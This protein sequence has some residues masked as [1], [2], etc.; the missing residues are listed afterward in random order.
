MKSKKRIFGIVL[1]AIF[2]S[3]GA[4]GVE[5]PSFPGGQAA[6]EKYLSENMQYPS[7]ARENGVEGVVTVGFEVGL[8]GS[9]NNAKI[10]KFVDPDL[11]KE[12]LRLVQGMPKWEPAQEDGNPVESSAEVR[13]PFILE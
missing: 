10:L 8:D 1:S 6:L 7:Y 9:I 2:V 12:A 3:L 5:N 4:F 13:I 11:E